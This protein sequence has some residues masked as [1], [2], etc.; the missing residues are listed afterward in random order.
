MEN[1][2]QFKESCRKIT[3]HYFRDWRVEKDKKPLSEKAKKIKEVIE[4]NDFGCAISSVKKLVSIIIGE[5]ITDKKIE[6]EVFPMPIPGAVFLLTERLDGHNYSLNT[7]LLKSRDR[8]ALNER[9]GEGNQL[10]V[11]SCFYPPTEKEFNR[12][13]EGVE[14]WGEIER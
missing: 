11:K 7:P 12:F 5:N 4:N 8:M 2:E 13:F 14:K 3:L 1:F 10:P 6:G 9:N